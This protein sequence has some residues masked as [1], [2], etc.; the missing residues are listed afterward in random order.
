M[1]EEKRKSV[2][3]TRRD[4]R[5]LEPEEEEEEEPRRRRHSGVPEEG[6]FD[7]STLWLAFLAFAFSPSPGV[8]REAGLKM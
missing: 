8:E 4:S 2:E 1:C 7:P 6:A 5:A 3:H